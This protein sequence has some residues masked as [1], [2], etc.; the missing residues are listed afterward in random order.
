MTRFGI[1]TFLFT[2]AFTNAA[3]ALFA[4]FSS[5]GFDSVEIAMDNP[6]C[7]DSGLI[8]EALDRHGLVCGSVCAA[9]GPGRDLRGDALEQ[10]SAVEYLKS[11]IRL[12]PQLGCNL[13]AGPLYSTVGRANAESREDYRR[14]WESVVNHLKSLSRYAADFGIRLA[15]EPL[16][17]YETDFVNTAKQVKELVAAVDSPPIMIHLDS[18]HMNIE[19]K[20]PEEAILLAGEKLG[21]FHACG[22]DRGTPGNDHTNWS[23]IFSALKQIGYTGDIVIESFTPDVQII[24]KA[25]SIWRQIEPSQKDIAIDG[26][27]FLR[28]QWKNHE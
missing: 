26:L 17:R 25:A 1:N 9:M 28:S 13:L 27:S 12:L 18:Y 20:H 14:Q 6:G 11:C 23:G 21:H 3:T 24:A 5:W 4:D 15:I 22:T 2:G 7:I 19:E 16:N 8:K 10:A